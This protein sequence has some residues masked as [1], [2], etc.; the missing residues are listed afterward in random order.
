M[1][2]NAG[3]VVF[4]LHFDEVYS[5]GTPVIAYASGADTQ[6]TRALHIPWHSGLQG[7]CNESLIARFPFHPVRLLKLAASRP[8]AFYPPIVGCDTHGVKALHGS[9]ARRASF[10]AQALRGST[11]LTYR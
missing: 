5:F 3:Q 10:H 9:L 11:H 8:P 1:H 7:E 4:T 2:C 6:K